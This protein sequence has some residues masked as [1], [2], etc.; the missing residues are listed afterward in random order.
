VGLAHL[1]VGAETGTFLYWP[2]GV[3]DQIEEGVCCE[4]GHFPNKGQRASP[5]RIKIQS[6]SIERGRKKID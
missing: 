1:L 4:E 2:F 6:Q 3:G 5:K